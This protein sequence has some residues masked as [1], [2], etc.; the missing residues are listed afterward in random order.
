M[1][2]IR[3]ESRSY[4]GFSVTEPFKNDHNLMSGSSNIKPVA[5]AT[6]EKSKEASAN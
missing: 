4:S 3:I 1:C 2:G 6:K 5:I